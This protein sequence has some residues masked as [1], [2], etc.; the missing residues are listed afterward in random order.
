MSFLKIP[1]I[2]ILII[3]TITVMIVSLKFMDVFPC[4]RAFGGGRVCLRS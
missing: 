3:V 4:F 1:E 2:I